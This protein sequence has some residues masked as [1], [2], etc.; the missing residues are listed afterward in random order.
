MSIE[1]GDGA[2]RPPLRRGREFQRRVRVR[3][4]RRA[5]HPS[6]RQGE[7]QTEPKVA[8]VIRLATE[9]LTRQS[10]DLQMAVWAGGADGVGGAT[11]SADLLYGLLDMRDGLY[12]ELDGDD[13]E[14][15]AAKG[16]P[17]T[18]STP[19]TRCAAC[20]CPAARGR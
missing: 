16:W 15:R 18:T 11:Q 13:A 6:L 5:D 14:E 20:R 10:K 8:D 9:V 19:A 1:L 12:P 3:G 17:G 2:A 7:W 4:A